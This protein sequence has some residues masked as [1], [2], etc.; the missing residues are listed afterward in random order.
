M[1]TIPLYYQDANLMEFASLILQIDS[2]RCH[3][4]LAE[5]AFYPEGGGQPADAGTINGIRVIDVRKKEGVI[6]HIL[7]TPLP[8]N[9]TSVKGVVDA[10]R[11]RD[12]MQQHTGQ[13]LLSGC[14]H[15]LLRRETVSVH[16]GEEYSSIEVKESRYLSE[17]EVALLEDKANDYICE[18]RQICTFNVKEEDI[19]SYKLRRPAR[20]KGSIRL[21]EIDGTDLVACGG[22]HCSTTG[23][24]KLVKILS[25]QLLRGNLRIFFCIGD[26][27]RRDYLRKQQI[28]RTLA[29]DL[30]A[31]VE[32]ILEKWRLRQEETKN[33]K[34]ALQEWKKREA[35]LFSAALI[36][37]AGEDP[38]VYHWNEGDCDYM[39]LI[40]KQL[41]EQ[42]KPFCLT[43]V[44]RGKLQW[45]IGCAAS[46]GFPFDE[47][48]SL[49]LKAIDG[50][51][52]GKAPLWQGVGNDICG[53]KA[54]Q[55]SFKGVGKFATHG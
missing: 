8:E 21:V 42:D 4:I 52:G 24:V 45:A 54:L 1:K 47:N 40:S 22:V 44:S 46:C 51:G 33:L 29:A 11:R 49:L 32:G 48:R 30:S 9:I 36:K 17:E 5:T 25:Q 26:R 12:F 23:E 10:A 6:T 53:W 13:H 55:N 41:L 34:M 20:V 2:S 14:L 50:N 15:K 18:N 39:K 38:L 27:A 3:L 35:A 16:L 19:Y 31:P 28:C 37:S 7:A 43:M